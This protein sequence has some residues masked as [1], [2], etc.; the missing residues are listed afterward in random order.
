[1]SAFQVKSNL[2]FKTNV[3]S[4]N[5]KT[6]KLSSDLNPIIQGANKPHFSCQ[7][8]LVST[9]KANDDLNL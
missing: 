1:M 6:L 5:G 9:F 3:R 2:H 7:A 8:I 4:L